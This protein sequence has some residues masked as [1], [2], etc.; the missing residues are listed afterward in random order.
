MEK[1]QQSGKSN[2]SKRLWLQPFSIAASIIVC[3]IVGIMGYSSLQQEDSLARDSPEMLKTET[4]FKTTITT[5]LQK[6]K[7]YNDPE[8]QEI[9]TE[10]LSKI[11]FLEAQYI[12]LTKDLTQSGNDSR[13][14]AAMISNFQERINLLQ[15]VQEAIKDIQQLKQIENEITL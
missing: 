2:K 3:V 1:L 15:D 9:I 13:L 10:A 12:E 5:E 8:L 11:D 14:I 6:L 7:A 4:F